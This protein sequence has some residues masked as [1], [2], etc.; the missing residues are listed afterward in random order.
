MEPIP[1]GP[2]AVWQHKA[3]KRRL[4][5]I[6]H[7]HGINEHSARHLHTIDYLTAQGWEVVRFDQRGCGRSGGRRNWIDSWNDYVEDT[8]RVFN[9]IL[10]KNDPA[11]T[12]LLGHSLGGAIGT[13]FAAVHHRELCGV[14]LSAPA[15]ITGGG[16]KPWQIS[17]GRA[18]NKIA[19]FIP[20]P[21]Q[22][23]NFIS[24]DPEVCAAYKKDP[25]CNH[26]N[27]VRQG[28]EVLDALAQMPEKSEAIECP[29]FLAHGSMDQI[30]R[31]EGSF[32]L[33]N[34]YGSRD[35]TMHIIP[36]G[37][38]EP[39]NDYDK[40]I[41]FAALEMWLRNHLPPEG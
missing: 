13:H 5:R 23:N 7:I 30:I 11:P 39:H 35:R 24:R 15:Y 36:G 21:A 33:L 17:I 9:W 40:E 6:L 27:P 37:Y 1:V 34:C 12:F 22:H 25:L 29:I 28:N 16:I 41:Y 3:A 32:E 14:A 4:G 38:H 10:T 31:L 18:L 20:I 8:T 19:P 26:F 2:L